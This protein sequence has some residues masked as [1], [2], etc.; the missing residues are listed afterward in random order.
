MHYART[1]PL[2]GPLSASTRPETLEINCACDGSDA[3]GFWLSAGKAANI[4]CDALAVWSAQTGER[5]GWSAQ[6][7]FP[8]A[9]GALKCWAW[10]RP[11]LLC[12]PLL[13]LAP[14][15]SRRRA[16]APPLLSVLHLGAHLL[17]RLSCV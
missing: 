12:I 2:S 13:W 1:F 8:L 6:M 16:A 17:R 5:D 14:L 9:S 11:S 15:A 7:R 10:H 4:E 3:R